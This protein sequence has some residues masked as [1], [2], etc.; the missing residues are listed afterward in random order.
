MIISYRTLKCVYL[1]PQ[2]QLHTSSFRDDHSKQL[3]TITGKASAEPLREAL[4]KGRDLEVPTPLA[5]LLR[6]EPILWV[7]KNENN[8]NGISKLTYHYNF[9][10]EGL[11]EQIPCEIFV[12]QTFLSASDLYP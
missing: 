5:R 8:W 9:P 2:A 3:R 7:I 1:E 6:D 11:H 10:G 4:R 12:R